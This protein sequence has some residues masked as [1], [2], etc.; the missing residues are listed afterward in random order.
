MNKIAIAIHGGAGPDSEHIKKNYEAYKKGLEDALNSGYK[1]LEGG[2]SALD[3]VEAAVNSMEDN[4]LFNAGK[5]S[6]LN[7]KA[8]VEMCAGI[9]DGRK[10]ESGAVALIKNVKNPIS[11]ARAVM[12]K[13]EHLYLG[14]AGALA[15]A[16]KVG[17]EL[18]PDAYFITE[19][20][21][22][23][24]DEARKEEGTNIR[25]LGKEQIKKHSHGTVGAVALDKDGNLAAATSTGGTENKSQGRIGDSSMIG[26]GFYAN[27]KT[28]A[29]SGTGDGE[30][31][32]HFV[33]AYEISCLMEYKGLSVTEACRFLIHEKS[34][35]VEGDMGL[36][37]VDAEGNIALEYKAD[38]MHRAWRT[39]DADVVVKIYAE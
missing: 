7:A 8:E 22:E 19:H 18:M 12:E 23:Q 5:G 6:A 25:Y 15:F 16:Q 37:A 26:I 27:N 17:V 32:M 20:A 13:S 21:Y 30:V 24:F 35:G 34:K 11:L 39:N 36:I 33:S 28:C 38:R 1:I 4:P 14:D 3:A 29:V 10:V 9:M 2:G 31:M